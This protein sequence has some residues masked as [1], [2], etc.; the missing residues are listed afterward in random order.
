MNM[1]H[2]GPDI[3]EG[4]LQIAQEEYADLNSE[5]YRDSIES[6]ARVA[7]GLVTDTGRKGIEQLNAAFFD[8]LGF[9][10]NA[11][12]YYDPRNSYVNDVIDR[13]TGIPISLA[14]VYCEIGRRLGLEIHG[15][16]FPGHFL[17]RYESAEGDFIVDCFN[18]RIMSREDCQ[19]LLN[20][21]YEGRLRLTDDMLH[22]SPPQEILSRMLRNLRNVHAAQGDLAR[23]LRWITMDIDLRPDDLENYRE[24][25]LI[26]A[27]LDQPARALADMERYVASAPEGPDRDTVAQQ[28]SLLRRLL[29][30]LN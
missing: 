27:R 14:T 26:Y 16:A 12:D 9:V 3:F 17:V 29:S 15:V 28:V 13:R 6:L 23:T 20:E 2:L 8:T 10:G 1:E 30:Q 4:A 11:E 25:G 24:R 22:D 19:A 18:G 7:R 21:L 5:R